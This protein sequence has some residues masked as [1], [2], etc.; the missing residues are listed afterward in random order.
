MYTTCAGSKH[1]T[2]DRRIRHQLFLLS[3]TEEV[4]ARRFTVREFILEQVRVGIDVTCRIAHD[5]VDD[6]LRHL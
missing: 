6:T 5:P 3:M 2:G 1:I 4:A